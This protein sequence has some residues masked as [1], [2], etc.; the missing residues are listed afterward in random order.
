M[1]QR[2]KQIHLR[3]M[4]R[5]QKDK[6]RAGRTKRKGFVLL[7]TLVVLGVVGV[8]LGKLALR[9]HARQQ[10]TVVEL[11]RL[12]RRLI[13]ESAESTLL[14]TG[15]NLSLTS[16]KPLALAAA[17]VGI[18]GKTVTLRWAN[19]NAKANINKLHGALGRDGFVAALKHFQTQS[20]AS[21]LRTDGAIKPFALRASGAQA[22]WPAFVSY[23]QLM[24]REAVKQQLVESTREPGVI[25]RVTLWGS[26]R[27][28][29]RLADAPTLTLALREVFSV[30][31]SRKVAA[32][33]SKMEITQEQTYSD[34]LKRI[35]EELRMPDLA[36]T[37]KRV[38]TVATDTQSLQLVI[39]DGRRQ[40]V[41]V[42]IDQPRDGTGGQRV[43]LSW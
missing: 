21:S 3:E 12:Q 40:D 39:D 38:L 36:E 19:E 1:K 28:D 33:L 5:C 43:Q 14:G 16:G 4:N 34:E 13:Q 9:V 23:D 15:V 18:G 2:Y 27:V 42:Y 37:L 25:D 31:N 7:L 20:G 41:V 24:R 11:E 30:S 32:A 22:D 6:E 29:L 10:S 17:R 8:V 35:A 26:G